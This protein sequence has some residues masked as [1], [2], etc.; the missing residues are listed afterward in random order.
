MNEDTEEVKRFEIPENTTGWISAGHH[1]GPNRVPPAQP[2][3]WRHLES[4]AQGF[5]LH[6]SDDEAPLCWGGRGVGL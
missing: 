2:T 4:Q 5:G 1:E 3:V 6:L